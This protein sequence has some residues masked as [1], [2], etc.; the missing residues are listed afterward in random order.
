MPN[1]IGLRNNLHAL[2]LKDN[3]RIYMKC[4]LDNVFAGARKWKMLNL[5]ALYT[6]SKAAMR[7]IVLISRRRARNSFVSSR[8]R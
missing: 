2:N 7:A 4:Y 6:G 1:Y 3:A 8:V 5:P